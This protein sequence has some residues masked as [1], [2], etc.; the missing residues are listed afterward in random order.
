MHAYTD[1]DGMTHTNADPMILGRLK[2]TTHNGMGSNIIEVADAPAPI[3]TVTMTGA[4]GTISDVARERVTDDAA[5]LEA[6]GFKLAPTVYAPGTRVVGLGVSNFAHMR[7]KLEDEPT[8]E[9]GI[10]AAA[11]MVEAEQRLDVKIEL[12]RLGW[13]PEG[14]ITKGK[15]DGFAMELPAARQ[16][17]DLSGGFKARPLGGFTR[18]SS[19]SAWVAQLPIADRRELWEKAKQREEFEGGKTVTLRTRVVGGQRQVFAVVSETYG[20]H[21]AD[22]TLRAVLPAFEGSGMR[23]ATFYDPSTARLHVEGLWMPD[24]VVDL[25]A[26]DV[27]KVGVTVTTSDRGDGSLK[28]T[29]AVW[30]N[31]CLNLIILDTPKMNLFTRAH[32]G[33]LSTV[34]GD[35]RAAVE[36]SR[37][38]FA[39]FAERWGK[40]RALDAIKLVRAKADTD[41]DTV[42]DVFG[43]LASKVSTPG[44]RRDALVEMLLSGHAAEGGGSDAASV[45]NAVTRLHE[46]AIPVPVRADIEKQAGDLLMAWSR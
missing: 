16:L 17:L 6:L 2:F 39:P 12:G 45:L 21:D 9:E 32:R 35:L 22:K 29:A 11:A 33:D 37:E 4:G 43:W 42:S 18:G 20:E 1:P 14:R 34:G 25:A 41:I 7:S 38:V 26:G 30:R 36:K 15:G 13:T 27:F 28:V 46:Q 5:A 8:V 40:L 23:G 10:A 24:H 31:L 19:A 3:G 44:I